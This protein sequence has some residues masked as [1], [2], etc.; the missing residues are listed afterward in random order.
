MTASTAAAVAVASV[1]LVLASGCV[2][3]YEIPVEIPLQAK[4]DVANFQRVLVFGF[5]SG[6]SNAIDPN[7]ETARLLRSQLRSKQDLKVIDSDVVSLVD[8]VDRQR[9][10]GPAP[11]AAARPASTPGEPGAKNEPRIKTDKDLQDYQG[12]F[13]DKDYWKAIGERYQSPL[14]ITGTVMFT[15]MSKS[16]M[17]SRP[18]QY[19]DST[20]VTRYQEVH[21]WADLKGYSLDS[22]FIFIDGRTGEQ[23]YTEPVHEES[24]YPSTQSTPALSSYFELMD[25]VLPSFL[26]TL[27]TQK[28]R[29]TR[30]LIK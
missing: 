20:G 3:F 23:L 29:G 1:G 28:I 16:G 21:E 12:I 15:E 30:I 22:K 13:N 2:T 4:I 14:I 26:N 8:E 5:L 24:L 25:K 7:T 17:V 19:I 11:G 27:S 18:Q 9:G 10:T 6:G